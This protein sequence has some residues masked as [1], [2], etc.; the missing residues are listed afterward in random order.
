M[1][2]KNWSDIKRQ[3]PT[4]QEARSTAHLENLAEDLG[5]PLAELR[6]CVA[7]PC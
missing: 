2:T 7:R 6:R 1:A 4:S 3:R 5:L